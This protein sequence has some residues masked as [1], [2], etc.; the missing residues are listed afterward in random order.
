MF[1]FWCSSSSLLLFVFVLL[2]GF[3][4]WLVCFFGARG[5]ITC[6]IARNVSVSYALTPLN[7]VLCAV[8]GGTRTKKR[9]IR[10]NKMKKKNES[11]NEPSITRRKNEEK[12]EGNNKQTSGDIHP[13]A[14]TRF[15][16][17]VSFSRSP[18]SPPLK[19]LLGDFT[20]AAVTDPASA[21]TS[22]NHHAHATCNR[23]RS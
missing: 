6:F 18:S 8:R 15:L 14:R 4:G 7:D 12:Y 22:R 1:W 19:S 10:R 17:P 23:S 13:L 21:N 3:V 2:I 20:T 9:T 16:L 5:W 11:I